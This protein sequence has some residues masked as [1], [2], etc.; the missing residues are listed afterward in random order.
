M[1]AR[2]SRCLVIDASVARASGGED[3][4][5]PTSK[6]CRDFLTAV[7]II[8]HRIVMTPEISREWKKHQS[9]FAR[10]WHVSMQARRKVCRVDAAP[11]D[12][13]YNKV[14]R[15]A[16]NEKDR[17]AMLNDLHLVEA[18]LATDQIVVSLDEAARGLF[19]D[20]AQ[21][22]G[23]L[24]NVVWVNPDRADERP[25]RWLEEGA[26]PEKGRQLGSGA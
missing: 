9:N 16:A 1:P 22:V 19:A 6:R 2:A 12:G 13:L 25:V 10:Q 7:R 23:E 20:T 5:Y 8:C 21:R 17:E 4:T 18:A 26:R 3:A 11:N 24:K 14:K 15:E